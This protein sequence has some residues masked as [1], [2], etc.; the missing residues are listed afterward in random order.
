MKYIV[1]IGFLFPVVLSLLVVAGHVL[2][3]WILKG[4]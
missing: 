4:G 2:A 3:D 1:Y